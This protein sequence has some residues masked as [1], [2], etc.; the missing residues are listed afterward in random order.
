MY[1]GVNDMRMRLLVGLALG[2]GAIAS[3]TAS[4]D[5]AWQAMRDRVRIGC[6]EKAA[7]MAIGKVEAVVDPFGTQS[8]GVALLVGRGSAKRQKLA[9]VCMMDKRTKEFEIGGELPLP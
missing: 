2:W 1:T 9:Y 3:A 6:L 7:T 4:S 8:H 5:N